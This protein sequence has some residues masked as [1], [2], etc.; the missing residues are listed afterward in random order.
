MAGLF[1]SDLITS[2]G[3]TPTL[4]YQPLTD[5]VAMSLVLNNGHFGTLPVS[6]WIER[7]ED[8][9]TLAK[10]VRVLAGRPYEVLIG[11]KVAFKAG[12]KVFAKCPV[13]GAF[14]GVLPAYKDQ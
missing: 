3:N 14:T 8:R 4:V 7:G 6:V 5:G 11:S 13:A 9:I 10:D 12:D 1:D 2:V